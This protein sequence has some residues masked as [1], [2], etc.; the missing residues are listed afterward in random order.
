MLL[1]PYAML[2][3]S[4]VDRKVD[5]SRCLNLTCVAADT[6]GKCQQGH[7]AKQAGRA[8]EGWSVF[9]LTT[10]CAGARVGGYAQVR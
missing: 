4:W 7:G 5:D 10:G 6:R 9:V 3:V 2:K 8:S 1:D